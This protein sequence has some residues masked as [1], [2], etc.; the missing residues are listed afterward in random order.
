[1]SKGTLL[2]LDGTSVVTQETYSPFEFLD[3]S[4]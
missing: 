2:A 4:S 1:M 3:I